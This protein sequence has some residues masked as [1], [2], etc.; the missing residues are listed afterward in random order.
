MERLA[1][2]RQLVNQIL[3]Q[4]QAAP[5]TE[6]CGLITARNGRPQRCIP[7][8]NV[9]EQPQRFFT[10]DPR[11]Q[12]DAMRTMRERGEELF[13]IYHSHPHGPALPSD[14]DLEQAAYPEALYLIVALDT[15]GAPEL[16][17][18]RLADGRFT[19]IQL[20]T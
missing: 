2:P 18:F 13:A 1:L 14:T 16:R 10:M 19:Q 11:C 6:I 8:P 4:A 17:G 15:A 7:V 3:Q 9:S 20:E 12:I 5:E